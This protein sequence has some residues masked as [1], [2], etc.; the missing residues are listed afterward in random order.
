MAHMELGN[1]ADAG[2]AARAAVVAAQQL[3]KSDASEALA[4][5]ALCF[6]YVRS[7]S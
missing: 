7:R 5:A 6:R 4:H 1:A 3:E 2:A